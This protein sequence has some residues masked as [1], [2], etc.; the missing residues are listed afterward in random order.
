MSKTA[1]GLRDEIADWR[2]FE[3]RLADALELA[4]M[5]DESM[6]GELETEIAEIETELGKRSFASMLS[7][8]YDAEDALLAIHAGAGGTDSQD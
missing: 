6:R 8:S 2:G 1:A 7:G 5:D 3:R 4:G